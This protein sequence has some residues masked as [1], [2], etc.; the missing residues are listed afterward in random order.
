[1]SNDIKLYLNLEKSKKLLD[2]CGADNW[3][4]CENAYKRNKE[5]GMIEFMNAFT[6]HAFTHDEIAPAIS[7]NDAL[8][9]ICHDF[10]IDDIECFVNISPMIVESEDKEKMFEKVWTICYNS[11]EDGKPMMSFVQKNLI[12][13]AY[14]CLIWLYKE[15]AKELT[16]D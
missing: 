11:I 8:N 5:T 16:E 9:N 15:M 6:S 1:M 2:I 3:L 10:V 7:L 13:A 14:E 12:D 4:M